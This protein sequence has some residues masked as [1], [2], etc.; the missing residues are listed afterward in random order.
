MVEA[1]GFQLQ[2]VVKVTIYM[3][4]LDQLVEMNDVFNRYFP[5]DQAPPARTTLAV[6]TL[7]GGAAVEVEAIAGV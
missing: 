6:K 5:P 4:D 1:G 2:D 3:T 7:V